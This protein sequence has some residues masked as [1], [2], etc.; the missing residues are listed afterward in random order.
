[1]VLFFASQAVNPPLPPYAQQATVSAYDGASDQGG[2]RFYNACDDGCMAYATPSLSKLWIAKLPSDEWVE[3]LK[4]YA[5]RL[6]VSTSAKE[7]SHL[8]CFDA[9]SGRRIWTLDRRGKGE[10]IVFGGGKLFTSLHLGTLSAVDLETRSALWTTDLG[11]PYPQVGDGPSLQGL[12]YCH[13]CIATNFEGVTCCLDAKSGRRLWKQDP[14]IMNRGSL[15]SGAAQ[16][17]ISDDRGVQARQPRTGRV[18]W[19]RQR[20]QSVDA[21]CVFGNRFVFLADGMVQAI[22]PNSGDTD[23]SLTVGPKNNTDTAEYLQPVGQTLF[24]RG[25]R[26]E[27][28]VDEKGRTLWSGGTFEEIPAPCWTG[29]RSLVC[30][31][32][33]SLI[34]YVHLSDPP[35]PASSK[36]RR[37]FAA[38]LVAK[39][40]NLDEQAKKRLMRLGD[41]AFEPLLRAYIRT[42]SSISSQWNGENPWATPAKL[43]DLG[44]LLGEVSSRKRTRDLMSAL[45]EVPKAGNSRAWLLDRLAKVGDLEAVA[46][47]FLAILRE[48]KSSNPEAKDRKRI[49]IGAIEQSHDPRAVQ[50]MIRQ[51][52]DPN[53]D[54]EIRKSA[55]YHLAATGGQEGLAAVLAERHHRTLLKP[56]AERVEADLSSAKDNRLLAEKK[57]SHGRTWGLLKSG[58]LGSSEDL[59]LAEKVNGNWRHPRFTGLYKEREEDWREKPNTIEGKT[60]KELIAGAWFDALVGNSALDRTST[61]GGLTDIERARLCIKLEGSGKYLDGVPDDVDPWP[62]VPVR[63]LTNAE[64][65]LAAAFEARYHFAKSYGVGIFKSVPGMAPFQMDGRGETTLWSD[66][67]GLPCS[68]PK[69][70]RVTPTD[71]GGLYGQGV[72][73]IGFDDMDPVRRKPWQERLI[74]WNKNHTAATVVITGY[75]GQL[76]GDAY[77]VQLRRLGSH[78]LVVGMRL[79]YVS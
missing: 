2:G 26:N 16:F 74:R 47:V 57:D 23:W 50:E 48:P 54:E 58:L 28:V 5:G 46:P 65:V 64:Q 19:Q 34:R 70:S 37:I 13:G 4:Y 43:E 30:F 53:A 31:D 3:C 36:E 60:A 55:Y 10:P 6:Y 27:A 20:E 39:F 32:G 7:I 72:E 41:D 62:N 59:W 78:W 67:Q 61:G 56:L 8:I 45:A 15:Y 9:V 18:L 77:T 40:D 35:L 12:S 42:A 21:A 11:D 51:L 24:V 73:L 76:A 1:M 79:K 44:N 29:D 33:R 52:R 63:P 14:S 38:S 75:I 66:P 69:G 68:T 49:A 17:Y 71:V 25:T 22:G